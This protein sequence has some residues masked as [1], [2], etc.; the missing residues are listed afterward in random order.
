MHDKQIDR[1]VVKASYSKS[2]IASL[3]EAVM[4][5]RQ[6]RRWAEDVELFIALSDFAR[7]IYLEAGLPAEQIVVKPNFV[8]QKSAPAFATQ[9][10][11][12]FIGRLKYEKGV[13]ILLD[14][15]RQLPQVPLHS[16]GSGP[17]AEK[18]VAMKETDHQLPSVQLH[19]QKSQAVCQEALA[20]FLFL[21][22]AFCLFVGFL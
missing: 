11:A 12:I 9:K 22:L 6:Q 14:A 19:G 18:I 3:P 7:E 21:V 8:F 5:Y 20:Q 2:R 1:A 4:Q 13:D 15:W 16:Y 17:E 10:G